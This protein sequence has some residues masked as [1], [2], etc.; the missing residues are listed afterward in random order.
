MDS[1]DHL[2]DHLHDPNCTQLTDP[3]STSNQA[4]NMVPSSLN[5]IHTLNVINVEASSDVVKELDSARSNSLVS[6]VDPSIFNIGPVIGPI[7][8]KI[9]TMLNSLAKESDSILQHNT[10][11][12]TITNVGDPRIP[13]QRQKHPKWVLLAVH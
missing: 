8:D 4:H 12:E 3:N 10:V 5:P 7:D 6:D 9:P 13:P 2:N 11:S 1:N